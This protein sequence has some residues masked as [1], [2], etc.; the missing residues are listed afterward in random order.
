MS[1]E[2]VQTVNMKPHKP[3]SKI[4]SRIILTATRRFRQKNGESYKLPPVHTHSCI[5]GHQELEYNTCCTMHLLH[6]NQRLMQS[7]IS[8]A[9]YSTTKFSAA[10]CTKCIIYSRISRMRNILLLELPPAHHPAATHPSRLHEEDPVEYSGSG[11][12][13]HLVL[14]V[15]NLGLKA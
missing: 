2:G 15:T 7:T 6:H 3:N 4:L 14:H 8:H 11:Y 13:V 5:S 9:T 12:L 10:V 1:K